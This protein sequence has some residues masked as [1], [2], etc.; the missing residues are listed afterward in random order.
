[1]STVLKHLSAVALTSATRTATTATAKLPADRFLGIIVYLNVSAAS[2]TGG[3]KVF[4]RGYDASGNAF[5]INGGGTAKTA[6]GQYAYVVYPGGGTSAGDIVDIQ[7]APVPATFDIQ[8]N[9]A[10]SSNYTYTVSYELIP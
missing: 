7:N 3:L 6:T 10:D 4:V 1:M 9:A 8:V 5:K 2:G